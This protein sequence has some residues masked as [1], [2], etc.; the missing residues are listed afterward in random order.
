MK[1]FGVD[2]LLCCAAPPVGRQSNRLRTMGFTLTLTATRHARFHSLETAG[3]VFGRRTS[4]CNLH[5]V[6]DGKPSLCGCRFGANRLCEEWLADRTSTA[7][8]PGWRH[9]WRLFR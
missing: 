7:R 3:E 2:A 6:L 4:S 5:E 9:A 8:H 1:F